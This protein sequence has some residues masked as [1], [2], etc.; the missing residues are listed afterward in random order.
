MTDEQPTPQDQMKEV[1]EAAAAGAA[2]AATPE[3]AHQGAEDAVRRRADEL[4]LEISD[5]D[6][7][8]IASMTV[9]MMETMGAFDAPPEPVQAPP[10]AAAP[11]APGEA[12]VVTSSEPAPPRKRTFAE[13]F[14]NG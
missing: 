2:T 11:P 8:K 4:K 6:A 5:E 9:K 12:P 14:L 7:Q 3:Q 1:G 13:K 10:A